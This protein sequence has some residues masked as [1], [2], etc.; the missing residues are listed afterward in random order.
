MYMNMS[1][2]IS[3]SSRAS[4]PM[5]KWNHYYHHRLREVYHFR[6]SP[7]QSWVK[8]R[9][10][11]HV[12]ANLGLQKKWNMTNAHPCHSEEEKQL[13]SKDCRSIS[14]T[15]DQS[16]ITHKQET[17]S[18]VLSSRASYHLG[19]QTALSRFVTCIIPQ[20]SFEGPMVAASQWP[21]LSMKYS[22]ESSAVT[23]VYGM[24]EKC[25]LHTGHMTAR[26]KRGRWI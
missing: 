4:M 1:H 13:D 26:R 7:I 6:H 8:Q 12:C 17:S 20:F 15:T 2:G 9:A 24:V 23:G 21:A 16:L 10:T 11:Y 14:L 3:H 22:G 5:P 19:W 25:S 18:V